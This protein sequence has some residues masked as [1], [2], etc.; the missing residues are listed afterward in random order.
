MAFPNHLDEI[1]HMTA[2]CTDERP[3]R[4]CVPLPPSGLV[5]TFEWMHTVGYGPLDEADAGPQDARLAAAAPD[6]LHACIT[7]A[8][9]LEPMLSPC[10]SDCE[11]VL[12]L[13]NAAIA[14]ARGAA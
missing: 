7:A 2:Q 6:L 12:H 9:V 10:D 5:G 1:T 4:I 3:C 13:L 14:K 8:E 11:C